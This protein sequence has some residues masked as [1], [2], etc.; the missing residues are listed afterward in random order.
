MKNQRKLLKRQR[1]EFKE[2]VRGLR[3]YL[4]ELNG[5]CKAHGTERCV[6]EADAM[7][8]EHDITYYEMQIEHIKERSGWVS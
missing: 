5:M 4:E 2:K 1:A 6:V 8:A 7:K 3:L